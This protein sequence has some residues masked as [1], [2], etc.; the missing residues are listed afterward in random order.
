MAHRRRRRFYAN[1]NRSV[2]FLCRAFVTKKVE[3]V[4]SD[5]LSEFPYGP[6]P[7]MTFVAEEHLQPPGSA[8]EK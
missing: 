6:P 8:V 1:N 5:T 3:A 7:V 2:W 4:A